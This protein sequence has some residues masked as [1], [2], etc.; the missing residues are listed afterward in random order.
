MTEICTTKDNKSCQGPCNGF[1]IVL[2]TN[3]NTNPI[4]KMLWHTAEYS[5]RQSNNGYHFVPCPEC[6]GKL[7]YR[8]I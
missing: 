2:V 7:E 8:K 6:L 4:L 1:G 3:E 5:G